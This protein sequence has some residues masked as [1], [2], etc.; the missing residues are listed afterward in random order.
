MEEE[1][2]I[3]KLTLE[4]GPR[5]GE[6]LEFRPGSVVRIGRVVRGNT[7]A[8]KDAGVSSKHLSIESK[9][10]KW[11]VTDLDSS[12]GTILNGSALRALSPAEL[13]DGDVVKIGE[14]TSIKVSIEAALRHDA[15][16]RRNPRRRLGKAELASIGEDSELGLGFGGELGNGAAA[17]NR[18]GRGRPRRGGAVE[19]EPEEGTVEAVKVEEFEN[20]GPKAVVPKQGRQVSTRR[21]RSSKRKEDSTVDGNA[22]QELEIS[23]QLVGRLTRGSSRRMKKNLENE[24]PVSI[25]HEVLEVKEDRDEL[26]VGQE[27]CEKIDRNLG[28]EECKGIEEKLVKRQLETDRAGSLE[29]NEVSRRS[30]LGGHE[31]EGLATASGNKGS[32]VEAGVVP[33]LEKMTLGEWFDYLEVYLPKQIHDKTEEIILEMNQMAERFHEFTSKQKN[34]KEKG[35]LPMG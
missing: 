7:L 24:E 18:R 12:N 25:N 35:K 26:N 10:G 8:I 19:S 3:L 27:E 2:T 30:N 20:L 16:P 14:L 31:C 33:D 1:G 13:R 22:C 15:P 11:V 29:D 28:Q 5:E 4:K 21:T 23:A 9:E 32:G 34:E 17:E 6:A